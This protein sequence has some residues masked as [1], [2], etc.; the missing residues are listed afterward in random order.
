MNVTSSDLE[1]GVASSHS[2]IANITPTH[3]TIP[4]ERATLL[5]SIVTTTRNTTSCSLS[6]VDPLISNVVTQLIENNYLI[7]YRLNFTNYSVNPLTT[8][9]IV[10]AY[11]ADRWSRISSSHG[12][13]IR[14]LAF[15][16]KVLSLYTLAF[17]TETLDVELVDSPAGCFGNVTQ[18]EK[19]TAFQH[20]LMRD[21]IANGPLKAIGDARVCHEVII[22]IEGYAQFRHICCNVDTNG[23]RIVC[24]TEIGNPYLDLLNASLTYCRYV[25]LFV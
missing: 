5:D 2:L 24:T 4:D 1:S 20:L 14:S 12:L 6:T 11:H 13:T 18:G 17:G 22:E 19:A 16:Y 21:F 15:N 7:D 3:G 10:D 23:N 25:L 9:E 8:S